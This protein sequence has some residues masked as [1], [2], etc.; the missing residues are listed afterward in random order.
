LIEEGTTNLIEQYEPGASQDWSKWNHWTN[1]VYWYSTT[2]YDDPI[3]GK[4]FYGKAKRDIDGDTYIFNYSL[5]I[6]VTAG[7]TY[8]FS[9]YIRTNSDLTQVFVPY[10]FSSGTYLASTTKTYTLKANE[11]TRVEFRLTPST[12]RSD[13]EYGVRFV[14]IPDGQ[15]FWI[16]YPQIEA[17]PY[18]TSFVNGARNYDKL[19]LP[20]TN[21]I[22][23]PEHGS[24]AVRFYVPEGGL[25]GMHVS[26]FLLNI[27]KSDTG[28]NRISIYY[29]EG[30]YLVLSV[31]GQSS[32]A[33]IAT[34][35]SLST[36]W[37]TV[38]GKWDKTTGKG[39]IFFD[40]VKLLE[41]TIDEA[42]FIPSWVHPYA[43]VGNAGTDWT[44]DNTYHDFVA[45]WNRPLTD[46]EATSIIE[47]PLSVPDYTA[48]YDFNNSLN[49]TNLEYG[50]KITNGY[51]NA[52]TIRSGSIN[53]LNIPL[54]N[55]NA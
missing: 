45:F 53:A 37:H 48:F 11:W 1:S 18:A 20:I 52:D 47:S 27:G 55:L 23:H 3:W 39:A 25:V 44:P 46:A 16:A 31:V 6:S 8:T 22:V 30:N 51:I 10:F 38:V 14:N 19:A 34:A 41:Q 36:G 17:K 13:M 32:G 29:D 15:E 49:N 4:V 40:G 21:D 43:Y 24:A 9:F 35:A 54:K 26:K 50:V 7:T 28:Y 2:Q 42:N 33:K 5:S 12:S